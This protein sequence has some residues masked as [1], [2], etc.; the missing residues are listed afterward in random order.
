MARKKNGGR[1]RQEKTGGRERH[2]E[3][4]SIWEWVVAAVGLAVVLGVVAFV[5]YRVLQPEASVPNVVLNVLG[6]D[7]VEQG[8]V[9]RFVAHNRSSF[10]ASELYV[11]GE[12]RAGDA[13]V[14]TSTA[15][16]DYLPA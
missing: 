14:E 1:D 9:V 15:R 4:A 8:F 12:L 11:R 2:A 13:V 3:P 16:I 10:T 6:I 7:G 5:G